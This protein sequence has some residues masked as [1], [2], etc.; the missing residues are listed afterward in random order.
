MQKAVSS[1]DVAIVYVKG[2]AYRIHFG[3]SIIYKKLVTWLII[4]V[5]EK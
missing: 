4:K 1:K 2:S 5:A 3:F